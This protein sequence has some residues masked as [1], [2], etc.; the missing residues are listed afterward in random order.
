MSRVRWRWM[1]RPW[2]LIGVALAG[3]MVP[4]GRQG[5]ATVSRPDPV[6]FGAQADFTAGSGARTIC[7]RADRPEFQGTAC[8]NTYRLGRGGDPNFDYF[9]WGFQ[10]SATARAG[11]RL[12]RLKL[13]MVSASAENVRWAPG[14]TADFE[15]PEN[16]EVKEGFIDPKSTVFRAL[17]GRIHP[18][19]GKHIYHVSWFDPTG[20]GIG[21]CPEAQVAA[22]TEWKATEGTE[23]MPAELTFEVRVR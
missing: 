1:P 15:K 6:V 12:E 10:G 8:W 9:V 21:C 23:M 18:Y 17:P 13:R 19:T 22:I 14:S 16:V 5:Q 4:V 11:H 2:M 20:R 3:A 7:V